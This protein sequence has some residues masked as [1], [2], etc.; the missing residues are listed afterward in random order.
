MATFAARS[1]DGVHGFDVTSID[2]VDLFDY[3]K[4]EITA[5]VAKFSDNAKNYTEFRGSGFK[6]TKDA[7]GAVTDVTAG[8]VTDVDVVIRNIH[9]FTVSGANFSAA[10]LFDFYVE[11][12]HEA[13]LDYILAGNDKISG[14]NYADYLFGGG[15]G[16]TIGGNLG[17]D[18]LFGGAG[19][20]K[21]NG[22]EGNDA[23]NG[24]AGNDTIFG[25][26]GADKLNG[27]IGD[28]NLNGDIGND[29]LSGG[30]GADKLYGQG[31]NDNLKGGDG[32]DLLMGEVGN[33]TLNGEVGNDKIYGGDGI[34]KLYG[35][36]GNDYLS[37]D[38]GSVTLDGGV[39]TDR[40]VGGGGVDTFVFK[41]GYGTDTIVDFTVDVDKIDLRGTSVGSFDELKMSQVGTTLVI[42]IGA[43]VLKLANTTAADLD[44]GDFLF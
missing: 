43:D 13:A 39:G 20:D 37:A 19:A 12:Q 16:D 34:D 1:L 31:G 14:T 44:G 3:D 41:T 26:A 10:K 24:D 9:V 28:D 32:D 30:A 7:S 23:L 36:V 18:T 22:H 33:D 42:T 35:G 40:L 6:Y 4:A 27:G 29:A 2:I 38:A 5:T 11:G 25:G 15:G 8:T 17:N 21:L